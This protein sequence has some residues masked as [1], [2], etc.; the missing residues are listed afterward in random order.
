MDMCMCMHA[1]EDAH[2]RAVAPCGRARRG[3]EL[4]LGQRA[5]GQ[6]LECVEVEA[7]AD[8][9]RVRVGVRVRAGVG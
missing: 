3:R 5:V 8:G 1:A 9:V 2:L 6:A 7:L 4:G